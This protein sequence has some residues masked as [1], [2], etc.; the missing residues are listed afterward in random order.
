M[1][2]SRSTF[3]LI[4]KQVSLTNFRKASNIRSDIKVH[5]SKGKDFSEMSVDRMRP[6]EKSL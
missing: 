4:K 6:A 2:N 3:T 5:K 1:Y